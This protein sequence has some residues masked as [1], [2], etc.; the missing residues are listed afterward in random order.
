M[1][2]ASF[3]ISLVS[4]DELSDFYNFKNEYKDE[5][6]VMQWLTVSSAIG[7]MIGSLSSG[8]FVSIGRR[9][10]ILISSSIQLVGACFMLWYKSFWVLVVSKIIYAAMA[11][12]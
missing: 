6:T 11:A 3:G 8:T 9:R 10:A 7:L 12:V 2:S 4:T 5:E 1:T